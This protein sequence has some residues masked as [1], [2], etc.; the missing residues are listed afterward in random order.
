MENATNMLTMQRRKTESESHVARAKAN[1][2]LRVDLYMQFGLSK[3]GDDIESVYRNPRN[4]QSVELGI[5]LPILDW[6]RGRGQREV[7]RSN[8]DMVHAQVEQDQINFEM[9]IERLVKQFNLQSH[10]LNVASRVADTAERRN[11]VARRLYLLGR[12]TILDL[13]ASITE[14]DSAKRNHINTLHTYWS[15]YYM[16]RSITLFDFEKNIP[17]TEDYQLLIK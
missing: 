8:R 5:R 4:Q 14:K 11:E 17:I 16:M 12:S 9:N 7:A 10:Q 1:T 3:T 2:G 6:G 15:L 13:N